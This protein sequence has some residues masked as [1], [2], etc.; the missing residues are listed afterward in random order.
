MDTLQVIALIVVALVIVAVI[1]AF[2]KRL[3]ISGKKGDMEFTLE[4]ENETRPGQSRPAKPAPVPVS[5]SQPAG[6]RVEDLKSGKGILIEGGTAHDPKGVGIE[7]K[8]LT[9]DEDII[10]GPGQS[11][12]PKAQPPA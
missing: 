11:G 6:V 4:A 2:R 1:I 10:I 3:A 5:P 8:K 9:A 12:D 7:A